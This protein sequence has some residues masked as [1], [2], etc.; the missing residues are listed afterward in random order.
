MSGIVD[1]MLA[2]KKETHGIKSN[3]QLHSNDELIRFVQSQPGWDIPSDYILSKMD[4]MK[5]EKD[6][7]KN[8]K[9]KIWCPNAEALD[10]AKQAFHKILF[11]R[12]AKSS[13]TMT[14]YEA[15]AKVEL[16]TSPGYPWNLKFKTKRDILSAHA[17][18][19]KELVD[20]IGAGENVIVYSQAAP[21]IEILSVEKYCIKGKQ[22]TF[23]S[24][25]VLQYIV[26]LMLFSNQ[27][28]TLNDCAAST[29]WLNTGY[30]PFYGGANLLARLLLRR[31]K[32]GRT[33][34]DMLREKFI[35]LD[36]KAMEACLSPELFNILYELRWEALDIDRDW[37]LYY[38]NLFNWYLRNIIY[39]LIIDPQGILNLINGVNPSGQLNT[40]TDNCLA[41][42][43]AFLYC[44]AKE[45]TTVEQIID[46]YNELPGK[47]MGDDSIMV[48]EPLT[49]SF[50]FHSWE[51]GFE[52]TMEGE[53]NILEVPFLSAN[54]SWDHE[55]HMFVN[56]PNYNKLL[57]SIL[58]YFKKKSWR[59]TYAKLCAALMLVWPFPEWRMQI[60]TMLNYVV[61]NYDIEM[62]NE[63]QIDD[64]IKYDQIKT[65]RMTPSELNFLI[66]GVESDDS[67]S[68]V[69]RRKES[70]ILQVSGID[71]KSFLFN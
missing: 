22:R 51:I 46:A 67:D 5:L 44:I 26:A 18:H 52:S 38:K 27:N 30:T 6:F 14:F 57:A 29:E 60:Q 15:L 64:L 11:Y 61:T 19:L 43:F 4:H 2:L 7:E 50:L 58:F 23:Q 48:D 71:Y 49:R 35:G 33:L 17:G 12:M 37:Y 20:K 45:T 65:L 54:F 25:C 56:K 36:I 66:Y 41:L 47:I 1:N 32:D 8:R 39:S 69:V 13:K 42:L 31:M 34:L 55:H 62:R 40:L 16:S 63:K 70:K 10:R 68:L 21:K 3:S 24:S 53:G 9:S 28:D 59:L